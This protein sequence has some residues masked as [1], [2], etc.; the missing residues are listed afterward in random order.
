VWNELKGKGNFLASDAIPKSY[1]L[2]YYYYKEINPDTKEY[3]DSSTSFKVD[4]HGSNL[5]HIPCWRLDLIPNNFIDLVLC[6]Q[7]LPELGKQLIEYIL[8]EFYRILKPGGAIY[9]RDL[10]YMY[11]SIGAFSI[12]DKIKNSGFTLEYKGFVQHNKHIH[13]IPRIWRK[14]IDAIISQEKIARNQKM[15]FF[16]RDIQSII[17][18]K[19]NKYIP[20]TQH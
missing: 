9:I 13:G 2:Q 19:K 14:N 4:V 1:G 18:L 11:K 6:I 12:E 17:G 10:G 20:T 15:K 3:L 7:V 8:T 5:Y 16:I